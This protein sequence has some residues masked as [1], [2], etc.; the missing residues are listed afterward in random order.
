M[1]DKESEEYEKYLEMENHKHMSLLWSKRFL[2]KLKDEEFLKYY[3]EN[4]Y[5]LK[6]QFNF[7]DFKEN[8]KSKKSIQKLK[9]EL[10]KK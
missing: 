6:Y 1:S 3:Y 4:F 10:C 8:N 5:N 7:E 9:N 2:D